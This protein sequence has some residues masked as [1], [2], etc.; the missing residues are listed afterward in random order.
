MVVGFTTKCKALIARVKASLIT[1][2]VAIL[3]GSLILSQSINIPTECRFMICNI[4]VS[5][6][7]WKKMIRPGLRMIL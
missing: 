1:K 6:S 5:L 7:Y 2:L 4:T 3:V